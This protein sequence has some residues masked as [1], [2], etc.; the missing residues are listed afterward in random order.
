MP[1]KVGS[2][3]ITFFPSSLQSGKYECDTHTAGSVSLLIQIAF[4]CMLFSKGETRVKLCGGTNT[5]MAPQIDYLEKV[6]FPLSSRLFSFQ[7]D[8]EVKTRGFYPRGGGVVHLRTLPKTEKI[9]PCRLM[10]RGEVCEVWGE[11]FVSHLPLS[12]GKRM[13]SAA[14]KALKAYFSSSS[15][16]VS[17]SV[18]EVD[19]TSRSLSEGVG[20]I[21]V[22][23]TT[24][25]CLFGASG[26]GKKGKKAEEIGEDAV[27][28]LV[29]DLES[30][31]C[32]D[33]WMQDQ[34]VFFS[35]FFSPL[36]LTFILVFCSLHLP[37]IKC[38][39]SDITVGSC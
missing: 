34:L 12:I 1:P 37:E 33:R 35:S 11:V 2:D 20:I 7:A 31:G 25:G 5:E 6:F 3:E 16:P 38:F 17:I 27:Q 32:V 13:R 30:G 18:K 15:L 23:T 4:P 21:L 28:E 14:V 8:L 26:I 24:T 29:E 19:E 39:L 22:A 36:S 9:P 10:E